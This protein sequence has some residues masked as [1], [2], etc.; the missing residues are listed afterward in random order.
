MPTMTKNYRIL[1][2]TFFSEALNATPVWKQIGIVLWRFANGAG[3]RTLE[4]TL[5]VSQRSVCHFTD[6]FLEAL[7]DIEKDRIMWPKGAQLAVVT[8]EFEYGETGLGNCKLPNVIGVMDGSHIPICSSFKNGAR[9]VNCK[10]FHT[11]NLLGIVDFQECF[12]Y[13]HVGEAG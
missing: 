5:G 1:A 8:H 7:L 6:Q 11:I 9:F 2:R 3:I 13:I 10:S 4:Q 12:T